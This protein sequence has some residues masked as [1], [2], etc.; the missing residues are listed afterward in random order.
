ELVDPDLLAGLRPQRDDPVAGRHIHDP[1]DDD[2]RDLLVKLERRRAGDRLAF[3]VEAVVPDDLE[4]ADRLRSQLI[5]RR[6]ARAREIAVKVGPIRRARLRPVLTLSDRRA[7]D[8]RRDRGDDLAETK[9]HSYSPETLLFVP[10]QHG[11]YDILVAAALTAPHSGAA[12]PSTL[13]RRPTQD[14]VAT[15]SRYRTSDRSRTDRRDRRRA[16]TT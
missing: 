13:C 1:V 14:L 12:L 10:Q 16:E 4:A 6:E 15:R 2:R 11:L 7:R 5:E 9:T 3:A 8:R